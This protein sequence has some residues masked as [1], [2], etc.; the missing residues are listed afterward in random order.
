[1]ER[2]GKQR[3]FLL[4]QQLFKYDWIKMTPVF[5]QINY[6]Y[7]AWNPSFELF[8]LRHSICYWT[9]QRNHTVNPE[10]IC[11]NLTIIF[12]P[13]FPISTTTHMRMGAPFFHTLPGV[14]REFLS[15][16]SSVWKGKQTRKVKESVQE[17]ILF[18]FSATISSAS[19]T[20]V[21]LSGWQNLEN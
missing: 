5:F 4:I 21:C 16:A 7:M 8:S 17:D 19:R 18:A 14:P 10:T 9:L 6:L 11:S 20:F 15:D 12:A 3:E 2:R 13:L 1:M